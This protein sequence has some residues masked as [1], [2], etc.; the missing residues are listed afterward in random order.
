MP[1]SRADVQRIV[2]LIANRENRRL[3]TELLAPEYDVEHAL[4]PDDADDDGPD[5]CIVDGPSLDAQWQQIG[6][7]RE[8]QEPVLLPVLLL[9]NRKDVGLVTRDLWRV[10]DDVLLRPVERVELHARIGTLARARR[11]SLRLRTTNNLYQQESRIARRFQ[12]TA[13][14]R[15]LPV[16]PGV[17]FSAY[18]E[19]G[20]SEA[21]IGGDWYD[22]IALSDRRIIISIG[23]VCGAGLE[24]AVAMVNVRHVLRA[25]GQVNP[26]PAAMLEGADRA[27]QAD[28]DDR[29]VTAF[30]A[31]YDPVTAELT[32]ASA[33]H[34]SP[35]LCQGGTVVPLP[36]ESGL[37]LGVIAR[38]NRSVQTMEIESRSLLLLYTDGLTEAMRD[39]V[40]GERALREALSDTTLLG[41]PDLARAL[42]AALLPEGS[43][44][45]VAILA[46][47]IT[48]A[49]TQSQL[50]R[51]TVDARDAYEA[52]S[53]QR[54]FLSELER[55]GV[56]AEDRFAAE[57]VFAELLGNAVRH[58]P[59]TVEIILDWIDRS[60]VL[61]VLDQGPGFHPIPRLPA[62]TLSERGRGVFIVA[63]LAHE[64][65]VTPRAKGGSHARAVLAV[66]RG[67]GPRK[68][69][70]ASRYARAT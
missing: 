63:S 42:S 18:Y 37:P 3:L 11:L 62:D 53:V 13:M 23:D 41:E 40:E 16:I 19:P 32:Y 20:T 55:N 69:P 57:L 66:H 45:D 27:L 65:H 48:P 14:P 28:E 12:E 22:A 54:A 1:D 10:V 31:V 25:L 30:V 33:G 9:S 7:A 47:D 38:G 24:A 29:M 17:R 64:F 51:W 39:P 56:P 21:H 26:D 43:S 68:R 5:L 36:G 49:D 34:P 61:H 4:P 50:A 70:D 2:V 58:A 46:V 60:P 8:A 59:S 44:D 35:L 6:A 15:A 52:K 67:R